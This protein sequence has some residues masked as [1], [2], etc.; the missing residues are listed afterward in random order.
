MDGNDRKKSWREIDL[1]RDRGGSA[2]KRDSQSAAKSSRE[3]KT[4]VAQAKKN[5]DALFSGG[6]LTKE[7]AE[8]KKRIESLRGKPEFSQEISRYIEEHGFPRELDMIMVCLDHRDSGFLVRFLQELLTLAPR[9]NLSEQ[10]LLHAKLK[11]LA[12]STFDA[13][14]IDAV[15]AVNLAM[16]KK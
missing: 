6:K 2:L 16:L 13:D 3:N 15:K 8:K 5:L 12:L 11:N 1:A 9:L 14:V 7:K 10:D 4:A